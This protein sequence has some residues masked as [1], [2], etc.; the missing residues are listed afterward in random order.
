MLSFSPKSV[1][2]DLLAGLPERSRKVL[3]D[4]FGLSGKGERRTLDAIGQE[5]GITRERVRQIENHSISLVR[6]S[7]VYA[8]LAANL[9][10]LKATIAEL[11]GVLAERTILEELAKNE[12]DRNHI[13]FLLTV[14]HHFTDRRE[15]NDFSPRWHVDEQLTEQVEAA[16]ASLYEAI[17]DNRLIPE[18]EFLELFAKHLKQAGVKNK[19]PEVLPRWLLISKRIGRNP[20]GEWGRQDSPH[21]R[22]K[23]T[24]DFAYL[25]L[26]RHGSPMHFIEVAKNIEKLFNRKTHSA[27]T[28]NELIKDNRFVLVGRGLYALKEWGYQPGVVRDVISGILEREGPLT[29]DE[30]IERVKRERYVKD[31]TIAVNLQNNMFVRTPE[32]K[33][34]LAK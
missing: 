21:V 24:R 15:D 2:K 20:L 8:A 33:Y 25:T 16:L 18:E 14:G 19:T 3:T 17:E 22:I 6:D 12:A 1:T 9:E 23:N 32:G 5:Y 7:E 28:H 10:H 30:I 26:K 34:S 29:R 4:R 27:T 13:L 31:A 11:G